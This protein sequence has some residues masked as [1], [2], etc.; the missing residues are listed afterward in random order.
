MA[1][2]AADTI[3]VFPEWPPTATAVRERK[4]NQ[5]GTS[6]VPRQSLGEIGIEYKGSA[7]AHNMAA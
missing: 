7:F 2:C 1:V 4:V 6:V 5:L 3:L